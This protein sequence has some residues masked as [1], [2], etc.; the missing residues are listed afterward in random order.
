[1]STP[2]QP[3]RF[4]RVLAI[5]SLVVTVLISTAHVYL[6]YTRSPLYYGDRPTLSYHY[7]R[8]NCGK[9]QNGLWNTFLDVF[10]MNESPN[11]AR[12]VHLVIEPLSVEPKIESDV[13]FSQ[14]SGMAGRRTVTLNLVPA[15]GL[16][17]VRVTEN[18]K[19]RDASNNSEKSKPWCSAPKV[20]SVD[21]E[22]GEVVCRKD[23]CM[24]V[25][26]A[27]RTIP[28]PDYSFLEK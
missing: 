19:E 13:T 25:N 8:K 5:V 24:E 18:I 2:S 11:P 9:K 20:Y 15:H 22:Y 4:A 1:M 21:T 17:F 6:V 23:M 27:D 16:A 12:N 7:T 26:V 10:V 3:D 14:T 28:E